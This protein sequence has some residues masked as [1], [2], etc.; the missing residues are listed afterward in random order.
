MNWKLAAFFCATACF[1]GD[2]ELG[3]SVGYGAYRNAS[4]TSPAGSAVAGFENQVAAGAFFGEDLYQHLSGE[5]RY[6]FQD[7]G[8]FLST[9]LAKASIPGRSHAVHYDF[10][11]HA[12]RREAALRPFVAFGGGVKVYQFSGP[13]VGLS[14]AVLINDEQVV[15]LLSVGAGVRYRLTNRIYVRGDFRDYITP[16]PTSLFLPT[17][18]AHDQG[19]F[20]QF[21]PMVSVSFRP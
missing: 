15:G 4:V 16:M 20:H 6:D 9:T 7:G 18:G 10:L 11:L 19:F 1:A 17:P 13:S 8:G 12:R 14:Q 3:L 21:T 2:Y 5:V